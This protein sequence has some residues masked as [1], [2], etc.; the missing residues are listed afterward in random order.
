MEIME[1]SSSG[2][3]DVKTTHTAEGIQDVNSGKAGNDDAEKDENIFANE[4]IVKDSVVKSE[5]SDITI[6]PEDKSAFID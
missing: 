5:K 1:S 2:E 3:P 4:N 6:T